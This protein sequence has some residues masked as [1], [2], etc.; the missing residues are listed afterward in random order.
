MR[1]VILA[2]GKGTRLKPYTVVLPNTVADCAAIREALGWA[3][4]REFKEAIRELLQNP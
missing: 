2:G 4:K 3:P 1:A